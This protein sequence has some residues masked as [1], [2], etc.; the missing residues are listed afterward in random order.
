VR[1]E[2]ESIERGGR[3]DD[4]TTY[5][6]WTFNGKVPGPMLRI[7]VG[8]TVVLSLKNAPDSVM[9]HNIDLH[10]VTGPGGGPSTR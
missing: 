1:Y 9:L 3:L 6:F 4:G 7:R 2:L 10:A 5:D 8:D